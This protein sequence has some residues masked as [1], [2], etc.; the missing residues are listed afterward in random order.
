MHAIAV[1]E[2]GGPEVF[3]PTEVDRPAPAATQVLV[4]LAV[5]GVNYMDVYQRNGATP[6]KPPYLAGVEG[7]GVIVEVGSTSPIFRKDGE[8]VGF[9]VARARSPT[10]WSSRQPRQCRS[11]TRSTTSRLLRC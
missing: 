11:L 8:S 1:N 6:V 7:V 4:E 2:V 5:S 9:P 10:S 3:T